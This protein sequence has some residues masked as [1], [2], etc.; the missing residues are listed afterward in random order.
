MIKIKIFFLT[1]ALA[2]SGCFT[3]KK[4]Q[5][6]SNYNNNYVE[7][8]S[9]A[10]PA[11]FEKLIQFR[12][13]E[14]KDI[15]INLDGNIMAITMSIERKAAMFDSLNKILSDSINAAKNDSISQST[16]E[17]F[18]KWQFLFEILITQRLRLN[19]Y[20]ERKQSMTEKLM[21]IILMEYS[22]ENYKKLL[23]YETP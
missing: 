3:A 16:M 14:I 8:D 10:N 15:L 1:C 13:K 2:L 17:T 4:V 23:E 5:E 12:K 19:E 9:V 18:H 22:A 6:Q 20:L 21:E 11:D 7:V